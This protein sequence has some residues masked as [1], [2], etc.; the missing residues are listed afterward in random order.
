MTAEPYYERAIHHLYRAV[1]CGPF[2]VFVDFARSCWTDTPSIGSIE[3]AWNHEPP[4]WKQALPG[5]YFDRDTILNAFEG[6]MDT[7]VELGVFCFRRGTGPMGIGRMVVRAFVMRVPWGV[8]RTLSQ[9][10]IPS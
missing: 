9:R 4:A 2:Y 1:F 10:S 6:V 7:P 3:I 8:G 5:R